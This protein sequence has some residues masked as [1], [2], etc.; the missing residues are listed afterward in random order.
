MSHSKPKIISHRVVTDLMRN[1][2]FFNKLP[3]FR[4]L[5]SYNKQLN[6]QA[7][8]GK[9]CRS[10]KKRRLQYNILAAFIHIVGNLNDD[11]VARLKAMIGADR[12]M[13]HGFNRNKGSYELR[14]I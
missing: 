4:S 10:C 11:A 7:S 3:E 13:Y 5:E 14:E 2:D 1:P 9:G 8:S 12:L 6:E